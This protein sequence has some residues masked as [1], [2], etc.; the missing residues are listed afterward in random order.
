LGLLTREHDGDQAGMFPESEDTLF[1]AIFA[2][3]LDQGDIA[4][5]DQRAVASAGLLLSATLAERLGIRAQVDNP[6]AM[7]RLARGHA[8]TPP[9]SAVWYVP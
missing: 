2:P 3:V 7:A 8:F 9:S 5:D 6:L 1:D 4:F